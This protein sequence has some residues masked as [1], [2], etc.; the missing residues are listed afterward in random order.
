MTVSAVAGPP[1]R[2][3]CATLSDK[4]FKPRLKRLL[5]DFD[6]W[7]DS[8][9]FHTARWVREYYERFSAFMDRF[10]VSGW[11]ALGACGTAVGGRDARARRPDRDA[12]AR[13]P[14]LQGNRPTTTG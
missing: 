3:A 7:L 10:H 5:L 13:N 1:G 4:S 2:R 9:V 11:R 14:G 8:S 6:A 12:G